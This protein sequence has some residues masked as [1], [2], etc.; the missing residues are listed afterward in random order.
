MGRRSERLGVPEA[1]TEHNRGARTEGIR[2]R[3]LARSFQ[4]Y[5]EDYDSPTL[6]LTINVTNVACDMSVC[7]GV[8]LH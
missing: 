4:D 3:E 6:I 7:P 1:T 2:G 5:A 8:G